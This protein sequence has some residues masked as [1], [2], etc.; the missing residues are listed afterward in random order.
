MNLADIKRE[1]DL[2]SSS[3]LANHIKEAENALN[4]GVCALSSISLPFIIE[5]AKDSL[6][7][8]C[9]KNTIERYQIDRAIIHGEKVKIKDVTDND[10]KLIRKTARRLAVSNNARFN[11]Y[12]SSS[13]FIFSIEFEF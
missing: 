10:V 1:I 2:C 9:N 3:D 6:Y 13:N 4:N 8:G 12:M 5:L 11:G 7:A